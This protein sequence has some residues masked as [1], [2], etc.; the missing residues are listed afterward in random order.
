MNAPIVSAPP[1]NPSATPVQ[2]MIAFLVGNI[3]SEP[4]AAAKY[5][6]LFRALERVYGPICTHDLTLRKADRLWN[7]LLSFHP[8]QR[9]WKERYFKS[10]GAFASRSRRASRIID[11]QDTPVDLI[12]QVGA[13]FDSGRGQPDAPVV[14]YTDYTARLSANAPYRFRS[15]FSAKELRQRI[16]YE[17]QAFLHAHHIFTR[18]RLVRRDIVDRYRI[19]AQRVSVVG[20]GVNLPELPAL[21]ER[22]S[23][24]QPVILFVGSDFVRKGGDLLL[25]AFAMLR[26]EFPAARLQVLTRAAIP[27]RLPL[28]GVEMVS[29]VWDR[30]LLARLYTEADLFALPARLETWGDVI[31]EAAAYGL[32]CIGTRGQPMEEIIK[33]GETGLLVQPDNVEELAAAVR[34]LLSDADLR[35]QMGLEARNTVLSEFTWDAVVQRMAPVLDTT[36]GRGPAK[37]ASHAENDLE[38]P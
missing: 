14:I 38:A 30:E 12:L 17:Q 8:D 35:R 37:D 20:G 23:T 21:V 18:S 25:R 32:P 9:L 10:P 11:A 4:S 16:E 19:P 31:L 7:A 5:G 36:L 22:S 13:L 27:H 1:S 28:A 3:V 24:R 15:P 29:P 33:H 2:H 26:P 6:L 34:R